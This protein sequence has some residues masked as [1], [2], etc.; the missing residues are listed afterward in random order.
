MYVVFLRYYK[1][2]CLLTRLIDE[3][4]ASVMGDCDLEVMGAPSILSIIRKAVALARARTTVDFSWTEQ[5]AR[6]K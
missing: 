5:A 4:F 2:I 6:R 1:K 3:K